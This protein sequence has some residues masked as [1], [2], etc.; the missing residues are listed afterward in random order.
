MILFAPGVHTGGG[1][2][3]LDELLKNADAIHRVFT[4]STVSEAQ[5]DQVFLDSRYRPPPQFD[6]LKIS[7]RVRP[8]VRARWQSERQ[9]AQLTMQVQSRVLM[10]ANVPPRFRL[11]NRTIVYLQNA[12]SVPGAPLDGLPI[13]TRA[14][15]MI[16]RLRWRMHQAHA[17]E[18]WVQTNF[19]V[20]LCRAGG[21]QLPI[22]VQPILPRIDW[23]DRSESSLKYDF[24]C[25]ANSFPYKRQIEYL[26]ALS[27]LKSQG[28]H[29]HAALVTDSLSGIERV[30]AGELG[31]QLFVIHSMDRGELLSL[32]KQ[33]RSLVNTSSI[34]SFGLP[35]YE[36]Q[37]AQLHI[38]SCDAEYALESLRG[39]S[40]CSTFSL[41][42]VD[43]LAQRMARE[44]DRHPN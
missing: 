19:M 25:V 16:E 14:R 34:E 36:G 6:A 42:K 22:V 26:R 29:F 10:F 15:L 20:K 12:F 43:E 44:L 8:T 21:L 9:L 17:D 1:K 41:G 30:L 18:V 24:L 40:N 11:K 35:L 2:V 31:E 23:A 28:R 7:A 33:S 38:I 27:Q 13:Q 5:L 37:Q 32:Y 39:Y 3:L 4:N